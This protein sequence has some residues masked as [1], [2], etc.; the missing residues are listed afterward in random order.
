MT[1]ETA[2]D[3]L[4]TLIQTALVVVSPILL[5]AVGVGLSISLLQSITSIQEQTLTFVPKLVAVGM[6]ITVVANWMLRLVMDYTIFIFERIPD[7][8]R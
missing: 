2:V 6:I 3:L 1:L 7:M 4:T 5:T 8:A